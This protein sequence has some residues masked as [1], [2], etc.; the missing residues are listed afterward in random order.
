M[1][2]LSVI[3]LSLVM[4]LNMAVAAPQETAPAVAVYVKQLNDLH[5]QY[6]D[7]L[8]RVAEVDRGNRTQVRGLLEQHLALLRLVHR[9]SEE[10]AQTA[11]TMSATSEIRLLLVSQVGDAMS[12][13]LT[14]GAN[15]LTTGDR[16]FLALLRDGDLLVT[17]T[18]KGL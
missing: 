17:T 10:S 13:T 12:Y 9:L 7:F 1:R 6:S 5:A 14:A 11:S 2:T 15:Y 16:V 3:V 18:R 8:T 4:S